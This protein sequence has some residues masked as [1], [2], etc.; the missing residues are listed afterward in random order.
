MPIYEYR[1]SSCG[2]KFSLLL[3]MTAEPDDERCPH[4][5]S[6]EIGRLVSRF[7]RARSEE[8]RLD[9]IADRVERMGEPDSPAEM[10]KLVREMGSAMDEDMGD[11]MEEMLEEGIG[12]EGEGGFGDPDF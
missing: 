2:R 6:V 5:G 7:A 11:E 8:A 10:R 3:G 1:C 4:C 9:E 12:E